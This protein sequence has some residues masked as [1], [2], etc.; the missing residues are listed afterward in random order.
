MG[1]VFKKQT[2]RVIPSGAEISGKNGQRVVRWRV[3]GKLRTAP[4]TTGSGGDQIVTESATYFAKFRDSDGKP[5]VR[6]TGCRDKQAAEQLLKKWEREAEQVKAGT[7]DRK[8]LQ[9]ARQAAVPLEEHLAAY[10]QSLIA[11]EVSDMY[12]ANVLRAVRR[13]AGDCRFG[14]PTDFSR[15]AVEKWL[16]AKITGE[17]KM[18][19]RSRNYYRESLVAFANWCAQTGRLLG[20]DLNRIPKADQKAD[21]KRQRQ[22]LTEEE[23]KRLLAVAATRPLT[24]ARTVRRGKQKGKG[25]GGTEARNRRPAPGRRARAG[26]DL[27]GA[28]ADRP[29]EE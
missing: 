19:A 12:R 17:E 23:L 7:L 6:P 14:T 25:G 18:G 10:E 13:V 24:D 21:P 29:T 28:G 3:R 22:A 9:A 26:A 1:S 11:A 5:V 16:A 2:T 27:Q 15:E 4:L 20:H 8:A